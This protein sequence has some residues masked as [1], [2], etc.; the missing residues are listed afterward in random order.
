MLTSII[1]VPQPH[2]DKDTCSTGRLAT[3]PAISLQHSFDV[4]QVTFWFLCDTSTNGTSVV[5]QKYGVHYA[6]LVLA[7]RCDTALQ[8][9]AA[10]CGNLHN[11]LSEC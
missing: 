3:K 6:V 2:G 8:A 9:L 10:E 7:A 1:T 4:L 11:S 5:R